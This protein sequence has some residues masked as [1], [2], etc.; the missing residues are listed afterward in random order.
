[1]IANDG[2][3]VL[4]KAEPLT[5]MSDHIVI[6]QQVLPGLLSA[7]HLKLDHPTAYQLT[8]V[9]NREFYALNLNDAVTVVSEGCHLW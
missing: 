8:K 6:P 4:R 2:V 7:L 3:L 1:M 9:F 5:Q